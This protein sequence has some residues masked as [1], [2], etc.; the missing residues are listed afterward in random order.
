M[1]GK[2]DIFHLRVQST[3]ALLV[4][5]ETLQVLFILNGHSFVFQ[6]PG[7]QCSATIL[8]RAKQFHRHNHPSVKR[9]FSALPREPFDLEANKLPIK[10]WRVQK[11]IS[12]INPC[13]LLIIGV[14]EQHF[15]VTC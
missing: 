3:P 12:D 8:F 5:L 6:S 4:Q 7:D 9:T 2:M 14:Q 10:T 13:F 1:N 11:I 15:D